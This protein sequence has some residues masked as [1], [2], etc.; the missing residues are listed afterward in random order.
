MRL[1][2]TVTVK[3]FKLIWCTFGQRLHCDLFAVIAMT[4]SSHRHHPDTV[5]SVPSQIWYPVEICIWRRLKL[6][7][8][9]QIGERERLHVSRGSSSVQYAE[10]VIQSVM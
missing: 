10:A 9:L 1:K 7:H 4:S 3:Y 6:A 2:N 8:H 5:L